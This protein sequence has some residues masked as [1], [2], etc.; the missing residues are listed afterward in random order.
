M[1]Q[2]V[3][4]ERHRHKYWNRYQSYQ[5]T[6]ETQFAPIVAAELNQAAQAMPLAFIQKGSQYI[7]VAMLSHEPGI[8]YF[9][10][11]QGQWLGNY[12]P[13]CFRAFP[14]KLSLDKK[15][16]NAVLSVIEDSGLISD[17]E[18]EPFFDKNGELVEPIKKLFDFLQQAEQSRTVTDLAVSALNDAGV[19][20][21]W[22]LSMN[23]KPIDG[24]YTIDEAKLNSLDDQKFLELRRAKGL[25][26]AY[27]QL[28]SQANLWHFTK[29]A[30]LRK[31][32]AE[33]EIDKELRGILIPN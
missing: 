6:K 21:P 15:R 29:L 20:V 30:E 2:E 3:S 7:L 10:N 5:F 25:P 32:A 8:N 14:F 24:F 11:D 13:A 28:L 16:N 23:E 4:K 9:I 12:V 26:V 22:P 18:G 19:I 27:A 17:T 31:Q 1:I 33:S